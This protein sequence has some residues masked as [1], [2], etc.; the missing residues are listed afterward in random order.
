M[1]EMK[2]RIEE[3]LKKTG[4]PTEMKVNKILTNNKWEVSP[5]DPYNDPETKKVRSI[6]FRA[7]IRK[8]DKEIDISNPTED[9]VTASCQLYIECKKGNVPWI[10]YVDENIFN[11]VQ[12]LG[13]HSGYKY[14]QIERLRSKK[15]KIRGL[16]K[17][18]DYLHRFLPP[19]LSVNIQVLFGRNSFYE[20]QMQV[21]NSID[22]S[23]FIDNFEKHL[24]YPLII[25]EGNIFKCTYKNEIV[26]EEIDYIRYLTGGI[27]SNRVS[28]FIDVI[29]LD[30]LPHYLDSVK[31]EFIEF[32]DAKFLFMD[33][34][35]KKLETMSENER[36]GV[37]P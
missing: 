30:F 4:L 31:K 19:T 18:T 36:A 3:E 25:Y 37:P 7:E 23:P 33:T 17:V 24:L 10:F 20:A 26:I 32:S 8:I 12:V 15:K 16:Y 2:K 1:E 28:T 11:I 27:P 14:S 13:G 34:M 5:A 9:M 35:Y 6:D 22:S 29:T 21:L